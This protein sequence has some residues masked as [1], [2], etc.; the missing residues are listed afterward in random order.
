MGN[1]IKYYSY[2]FVERINSHAIIAVLFY[3][4]MILILN[5]LYLIIEK[6]NWSWMI[7]FKS[8]FYGSLLGLINRYAISP[9]ELTI[10]KR[11]GITILLVITLSLLYAILFILYNKFFP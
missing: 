9:K 10:K 2:F 1:K 6:S 4:I 7:L 3:T 8:I 11:S 5:V